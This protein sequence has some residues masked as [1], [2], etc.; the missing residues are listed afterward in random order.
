[1]HVILAAADAGTRQRLRA[2]VLGAGLPC[3]EEVAS[4]VL[5]ERSLALREPE[6]QTLVVV[7]RE[8]A[9]ALSRLA[10]GHGVPVLIWP[11]PEASAAPPTARRPQA[12]SRAR[13]SAREREILA[14]VAAGASNKGIARSLRI[15]TNTV[16]FHMT[17]LFGKL[18]VAT[19]A[20]AIAAAAR[21][22]ELSL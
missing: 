2:K 16:K 4:P 22:G 6:D 20:E 1:V 8:D 12:G 17:T 15:S 10:L 11:A 9:A 3:D 5:L 21:S 14:L 13:L 19:R 18:G 7:A